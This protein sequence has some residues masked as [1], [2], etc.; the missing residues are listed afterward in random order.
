MPSPFESLHRHGGL[1]DRLANR[2]IWRFAGS[3]RDVVT[4][5][6]L[7][8]FTFDDVPDSALHR[9][10]AILESHG[11]RGTFYIAGG[12]A[13]QVE[14]ERVLIGP[15][16][17]RELAERGHEIGCHTFSHR[18]IRDMSGTELSSDLERNAAYLAGAGVAQ[19]PRNFAFPYNA[20]WPLARPQFR[21]RYRSCR[22]A[23]EAINRGHVDPQMLKGVEIRQPEADARALTRW[24]DDVA[25]AP[26]WLVFF[27]HDIAPRPTAH[28]CTPD[29]FDLLVAHAV[30]RGCT[31]LPVDQ[32][33]DRLGW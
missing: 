14:P 25:A 8:S 3:R 9:G 1:A 11:V 4:E 32:A 24:I 13:G 10:A 21:R 30:A 2:L 12:L 23:G 5:T 29:T 16:G 26:G 15:D 31:V 27:T 33:L 20:A 6:P 7:V 28:G 18:R 19:P 22:G 17:C